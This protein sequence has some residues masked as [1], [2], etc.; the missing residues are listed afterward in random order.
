MLTTSN[1]VLAAGTLLTG[2]MAGLFFSFSTA[3]IPGLA[4]LPDGAYLQA[5]QNI[6]ISIQNPVFLLC[7]MA[8]VIILPVTTWLQNKQGGSSAWLWVLAATV[9]YVIAVFGVTVAGNVPLND[10]LAKADLTNASLPSLAEQRAAFEPLWNKLHTI[11]TIANFL[12]FICL[13]FNCIL[14]FKK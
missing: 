7:F 2:L 3:I 10:A 14:T 9:L 13:T 6:N 12:A 1:L 8:P 4:Q 11:R 5:F